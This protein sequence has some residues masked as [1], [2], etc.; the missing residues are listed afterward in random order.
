[1]CMVYEAPLDMAPGHFYEVG[2]GLYILVYEDICYR[3]VLIL[4]KVDLKTL[5]LIMEVYK[6]TELI[7]MMFKTGYSVKNGGSYLLAYMESN[8]VQDSQLV[9][10]TPNLVMYNYTNK[11]TLALNPTVNANIL[12]V[13]EEQ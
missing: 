4:K 1:M 13:V 6:G 7:G 11:A 2:R 12:T 10:R 3:D 5:F 9:L 8:E